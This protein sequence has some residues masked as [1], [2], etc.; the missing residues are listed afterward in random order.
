MSFV[1]TAKDNFVKEG[2]QKWAIFDM[3]DVV[4]NFIDNIYPHLKEVIK[5][6][7]SKENIRSYAF[8]NYFK[9][10]DEFFAFLKDRKLIETSEI[11]KDAVE[12]INSFKQEGFKI[13]ILTARG[14]HPNGFYLTK[15][16]LTDHGVEFDKIVLSGDHKENKSQYLS[17]FNGDLHV[18]IDDSVRH[19]KGMLDKDVLAVLQTRTWNELCDEDLKRVDNLSEYRDF[20]F[21]V[22]GLS[23]K[24]SHSDFK[25]VRSV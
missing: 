1:D 21:D 14:W 12:V 9:S 18:F 19:V 25:K 23:V 15:K 22:L 4:V 6:I 20:V 16:Y 3:D 2:G 8:E 17:E 13:G 11:H 7:P 10:D 5:D 24:N